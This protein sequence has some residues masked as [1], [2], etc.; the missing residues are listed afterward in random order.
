MKRILLILIG[1]ALLLY[2]ATISYYKI[3]K[4]EYQNE[5]RASFYVELEVTY[6][7][8]VDSVAFVICDE[9]TLLQQS[10][11]S[12]F[13]WDGKIVSPEL[14]RNSDVGCSV[15]V[16]LYPTNSSAKTFQANELFN[17]PDCDGRHLFTIFA[18][19]LFYTY[20]P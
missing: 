1:I 5:K 9:R 19:D 15:S 6:E 13:I 17:C 11:A 10:E 16:T 8:E 12:S 14:I 4:K 2:I 18:D 7:L 20:S 3:Q